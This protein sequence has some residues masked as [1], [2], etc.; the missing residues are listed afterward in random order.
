[1]TDSEHIAALVWAI[2]DAHP[3]A[4]QTNCG[5][6]WCQRHHE[7]LRQARIRIGQEAPRD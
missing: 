6:L 4:R 3:I 7:T 1:M 5:C 2:E